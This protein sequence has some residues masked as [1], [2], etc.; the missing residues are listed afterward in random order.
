[1][2]R[3][4]FP[5]SQ[6]PRISSVAPSGGQIAAQRVGVRGVDEVDTALGRP[7]EDADRGRLVT[8]QSEGH[9]PQAQPRD[10]K[11]GSSESGVVHERKGSVPSEIPQD[12]TYRADV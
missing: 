6:R 7:V 8:L 4:R 1:M 9:R 2:K 10:L 11:A 3:S 5:C 12:Q